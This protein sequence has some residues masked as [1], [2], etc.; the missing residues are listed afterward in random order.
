MN[1]NA[2]VAQLDTRPTERM[3]AFN[4]SFGR[5]ASSQYMKHYVYILKSCKDSKRY[6]GMTSNLEKRLVEHNSKKT[7]STKGR[8]PFELEYFEEFD[9]FLAA[10]NREKYFKTAAGRRYIKDKLKL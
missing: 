10:R 4:R 5:G 6:I 8:G 9:S 7:K 2:P 1:Y 3:R